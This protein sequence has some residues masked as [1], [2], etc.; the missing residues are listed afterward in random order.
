MLSAAGTG[1]MRKGEQRFW[2]EKVL[3]RPEGQVG[4]EPLAGY[5]A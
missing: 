3:Q 5:K 1:L 4:C 2:G